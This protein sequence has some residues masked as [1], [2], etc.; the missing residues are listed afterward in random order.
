MQKN[1]ICKSLQIERLPIK[2]H[3]IPL[4][5]EFL[6]TKSNSRPRG[7]HNLYQLPKL[8]AINQVREDTEGLIRVKEELSEPPDDPIL[9]DVDGVGRGEF[10]SGGATRAIYSGLIKATSQA[11]STQRSML[12]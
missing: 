9:E 5:I 4:R 12:S 11:L 1:T 2:C 7:I 6:R 10:G 8:C 3:N